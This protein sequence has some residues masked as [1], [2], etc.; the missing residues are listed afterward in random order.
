MKTGVCLSG[1]GG[2][3]GFL[4][5]AMSNV[6]KRE[7]V[8][9][10]TGVS[11]GALV[12]AMASCGKMEK[13]LDILYHITDNQIAKKRVWRY[14]RRTLSH[15]I[16]IRSPLMGVYDNAPL[17]ELIRSELLGQTFNIDFSCFAVN[18][19]TGALA[20]WTF[21][22]GLEVGMHNIELITDQILS[23]TAIPFAF[24]PVEI[25]GE[26][27]VDGGVETHTPIQP[28]KDLLP[29]MD[30]IV[31]ISTHSEEKQ[32]IDTISSDMDMIPAVIGSL[33]SKVSEVDFLHFQ[34][35]NMLGYHGVDGY[36]YYDTSII[37]P[38][39]ELSPTLRFHH[40]FTR[41]DIA[42]GKDKSKKHE[43]NEG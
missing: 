1:A 38:S 31:I 21:P 18:I 19:K 29:D 7:Q 35:R 43:S 16:G 33:V 17:R 32:R 14:A 13:L 34:Y 12:G 5:G 24:S 6:L 10:I 11:S 37:T 41:K 8:S 26:L 40:S 42:H 27:Y 39:Q 36:K 30:K 25:L 23:S 20:T 4:A 15:F 3:I 28:T 2:A 9:K 22:A